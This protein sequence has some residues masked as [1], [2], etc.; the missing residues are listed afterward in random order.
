MNREQGEIISYRFCENVLRYHPIP[1]F[2]LNKDGKVVWMNEPFYKLFGI[3]KNTSFL[4]QINSEPAY[5]YFQETLKGEANF[6]QI[7]LKSNKKKQVWLCFSP[8]IENGQVVG[9]YGVGS[10]ERI[11]KLLEEK[12]LKVAYEDH[13]TRLP[14]RFKFIHQLEETI[15]QAKLTQKKLA[16]LIFD[17]NRFRMIN[18]ALGHFFGDKALIR[19][20]ERMVKFKRDNDFVARMGGDEFILLLNEIESVQEVKEFVRRILHDMNQP[21][22]IDGFEF[23]I[24]TSVGISIYPEHGLDT[25]T[26]I[27]TADTALSKAK[28]NGT[29]H[30]EIYQLEMTNGINEWFEVEKMLHRALDRNEFK[31]YFQPQ[32]YTKD[33]SVCGLEVLVRWHH[34]E[35]GVISPGKFI[36]IAEE[37]GLIASIGEWVLLEGCKQMKK[38]L[39]EGHS[40]IPISINVSLKQFMQKNFSQMVHHVLIKSQLPAELLILEITESITI[41][42]DRMLKTMEQLKKIGVKISLDDF[43]TG[44]SSLQ[45]LSEL[46]IDELKIDKSFVNGITENDRS[47]AII[48]MIVNLGHLLN[49]SVI[50]EGVENEE[51]YLYLLEQ[52]CDKIQGYYFSKPLEATD[53]ERI[54]AEQFK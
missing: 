26:L 13:L 24:T 33:K 49:L 50:A 16:I 22:E 3:E 31:L 40:P 14:N 9:V 35:N 37:T 8:I 54:F 1:T 27:K 53:Y 52:G 6:F 36:E 10:N 25:Q 43:G 11:E 21:Y 2:I 46:P 4:Q 34:P 51:Q 47:K 45:Y 7:D 38:W 30:Y 18:E 41:D 42:L 5:I 17:I 12:S 29:N 20:T 23:T 44:Y 32:I 28:G 48:S 39:D 15:R 19:I